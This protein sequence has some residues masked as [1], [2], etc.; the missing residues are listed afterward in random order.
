MRHKRFL[1]LGV[2]DYCSSKE[3]MY[4]NQLLYF[5][6]GLQLRSQC[7][8]PEVIK[9]ARKFQL[10]ISSSSKVIKEVCS[11]NSNLIE[12]EQAVLTKTI[13][14]VCKIH[15]PLRVTAILCLIIEAE[16]SMGGDEVVV[17]TTL[18]EIIVASI[19]RL[20]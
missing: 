10:F 2:Q 13:K 12:E 9:E 17:V 5:L 11:N 20:V 8:K 19:E 14:E 1:R 7:T 15:L 4:N 6:L 3:G 18:I 16:A